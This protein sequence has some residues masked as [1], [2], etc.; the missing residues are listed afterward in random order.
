MEHRINMLA[1]SDPPRPLNRGS[2]QN[3]KHY[4]NSLLMSNVVGSDQFSKV[5]TS[6]QSLNADSYQKL[7]HISPNPILN[8]YQPQKY[9]GTEV[10][11]TPV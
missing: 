2:S 5:Y 8:P 9:N 1:I 6:K 11:N 7:H 10:N 3:N 4:S